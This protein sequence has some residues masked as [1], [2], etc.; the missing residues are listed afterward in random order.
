MILIEICPFNWNHLYQEEKN[1][2]TVDIKNLVEKIVFDEDHLFELKEVLNQLNENK[3][4]L[5]E[6]KHVILNQKTDI[7]ESIIDLFSFYLNQQQSRAFLNESGEKIEKLQLQVKER[8]NL[9]EEIGKRLEKITNN[10]SVND[11]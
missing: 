5:K 7:M 10:N 3:I 6:V 2:L 9:L 11:R 8:E 1:N 4:N